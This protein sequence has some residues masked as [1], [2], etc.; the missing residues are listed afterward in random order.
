LIEQIN[1]L[2]PI[3]PKSIYRRKTKNEL[4]KT[5]SHNEAYLGRECDK[6]D[7]GLT[8]TYD[9]ICRHFRG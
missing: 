1:I 4:N 3:E 9:K 5:E 8:L 2:E 6:S 7:I